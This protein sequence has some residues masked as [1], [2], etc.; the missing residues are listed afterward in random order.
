MVRPG[1]PDGVPGPASR[2]APAGDPDFMGIFQATARARRGMLS[3][4]HIFMPT[5]EG[6]TVHSGIRGLGAPLRPAVRP[7]RWFP[8][9][10]ALAAGILPLT[11]DTPAEAA[12]RA[13]P[14]PGLNTGVLGGRADGTA[15]RTRAD[16]PGAAFWSP[17]GMSDDDERAERSN[18]GN[19]NDAPEPGPVRRAPGSPDWPD[20]FEIGLQAARAYAFEF[21]L[22][23]DDT[24]LA[25]INRI[26]YAVTS[27]AGH[28]EILYTFHILDVPDPNAFAL[29]GGF[30]FVTKG[31]TDLHLSDE[32]MANLLGH[33]A[34]HVAGNHFSRAGKV[35]IALSLLQTAAVIAALVAVPSSGTSGGYD[36]DP[37][38]GEWRTSLAGKDAAVQGTSLFGSVFRELLQRGYSRNLEYEADE[39]GRRLAVR[40]G[41]PSRGSMLMLENLHK[42]IFEDQQ[43]GYW[44]THPFFTDRVARARA[45]SG[46]VG[47]PPDS[48]EEAAYRRDLSRKLATLAGSVYDEP[49]ALFL[50]RS[51]LR[52]ASGSESS[53]EIEH[54]LLRMRAMR[55]ARRR[56]V[57][58]AYGP[59]IADYD[60]LLVHASRQSAP[61]PL[62]AELGAERD[63]LDQRRRDSREPLDEI[64]ARDNAGTPFLELFLANFPDDPQA[65]AVR[66][67]LAERY[68]LSDR[69]DAAALT[70]AGTAE[71]DS[72]ASRALREVLPLTKELSTAGK[73]QRDAKSDR[74]RGWATARLEA[75]AASLDSLELG[76]RF[77]QEFPTDPVAAQVREKVEALAM[78]R[79]FE[80]RLRESMQDFQGALDNYNALLL[81]APATH[82]AELSRAGIERIQTTAG[83]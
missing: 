17:Y 77:L 79:Y 11:G 37:E 5:R 28:P 63:S 35:N 69:A 55:L 42:H 16:E 70:L 32:E 52:A 47:A 22:V 19:P 83:R 61:A 80:A 46:E 14:G 18:R 66:L 12:S 24:L 41:Y 39:M 29:P 48:T 13:W 57:L 60:S 74:L 4:M 10:F 51:A 81:L 7:S 71:K 2:E 75:Q 26:G 40:A 27:Q 50:Q 3:A 59:L 15:P 43:F 73:I 76:S 65:S 56:P 68:R 78:K 8:I 62:R 6:R 21:G 1:L 44:Q 49:T 36:R 20:G 64:L 23:Q 25:R 53:L 34:W 45:A 58:R 31:M 72:S 9:L 54:E 82:A 33:E 67:R 30:I 38:T